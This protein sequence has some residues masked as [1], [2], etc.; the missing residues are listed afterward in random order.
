MSLDFVAVDFETANSQRAS[1]CQ[2]GLAQVQG[3]H[4]VASDAWYIVP[5]TGLDSFDYRNMRI[6]G[7]TAEK[8][9][10]ERGLSWAQSLHRFEQFC[11]G[12][13]LVAHNAPFDR[14]VFV[15]SSLHA[16]VQARDYEWFDS[17]PLARRHLPELPNHKLNTVAAHLGATHFDH[18]EA[19]ADA[20]VCAQ[21]VTHVSQLSGLGTVAELWS[22]PP[23][24]ARTSKYSSS[25][26]MRAADLPQANPAA[27]RRH[28]LCGET[29]VL[30]GEVEGYQRAE[31]FQALSERGAI[32]QLGVTKKTSLLVLAEKRE[33]PKQYDL[34][35]GS[36]KERKAHQYRAA[37][38]RIE[39]LSGPDLLLL[40]EH[41]G[42]F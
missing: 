38:Q 13:P 32:V 14:G 8:V 28:P 37:G 15:A 33:I 30:T 2:V 23:I 20:M 21:L 22:A 35:T 25:A 27:D 42:G 17:V 40:L 6:H 19:G 41:D 16:H 24:A 29:V 11:G 36:G 3:G 1:V 5:P 12:L 4:I 39:L 7:I 9:L 26:T 10:A 31:L 18:H 34:S